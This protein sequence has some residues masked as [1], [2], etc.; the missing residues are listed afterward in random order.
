MSGSGGYVKMP[1]FFSDYSRHPFQLTVRKPVTSDGDFFT[2]KRHFDPSGE[3]ISPFRLR[4]TLRFPARRHPRGAGG[5]PEQ[6]VGGSSGHGFSTASR[7]E[8]DPES[9][10]TGLAGARTR[11]AKG[12]T[13]ARKAEADEARTAIS[14]RASSGSHFTLRALPLKPPRLVNMLGSGGYVKMPMNEFHDV[15]F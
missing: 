10:W 13:R 3:P 9:E 14:T 2:R 8:R 6:A 7:E 5:I 4:R 12:F 15:R 11:L 1:M